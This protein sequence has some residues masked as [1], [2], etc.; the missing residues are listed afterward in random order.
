VLKAV[1]RGEDLLARWAAA[2]ALWLLDRDAEAIRALI[3]LLQE[4]DGKPPAA[5][6]KTLAS[7]GP[8]GK[9]YIPWLRPLLKHPNFWVRKRTVEVLEALS[10]PIASGLSADRKSS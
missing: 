3:A 9:A 1:M 8:A 7:L 4:S 2:E 5:A 6:A 10:K